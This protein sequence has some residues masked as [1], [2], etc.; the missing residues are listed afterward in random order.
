MKTEIVITSKGTSILSCQYEDDKLYEIW[1]EPA[2]PHIRLGD[3]YLGKVKN[4]VKNLN[5]AFVEIRPSVMGY[6]SLRDNKSHHFA[7]VKKNDRLCEGDEIL[8]QVDGENIKAKEWQLTGKI[9][10]Q[11]SSCV[12]FPG[13]SGVRVS[14]KIKDPVLRDHLKE[15]ALAEDLPGGVTI[16]TA[17]SS[18]DDRNIAIELRELAHEGENV[19]ASYKTRTCGS[20]L[21]A[22]ESI[23][24]QMIK[25]HICDPDCVI[26][27]DLPRVY[28]QVSSY[29]SSMRLDAG[30]PAPQVRLYEDENFS[31][32]NLKGIND[33]IEKACSRRVWL[34]SG[35]YLI[36]DNTEAMSV[37]DVN[38]WKNIRRAD[39]EKLFFETNMEAAC[40]VMR[41]IRLRNLSG[42]ILVDFINM[43]SEEHKSQLF[44]KARELAQAD[45]IQTSVIDLTAL[46]ILEIT[47]RRSRHSLQEML[48]AEGNKPKTVD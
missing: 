34:R 41:Q 33:Q 36:I 16:R 43:R 39:T 23:F 45:P 5:A 17:A 3:I 31:L 32:T 21:R 40:E 18:A 30:S 20:L 47:R 44:V 14:R 9:S 38:T 28:E 8:V 27:T 46:Q 48:G 2:G 29:I 4:I 13:G 35:G 37:I 6:Y 26:T 10:I 24:M 11:G 1:L 19:M 25:R 42:M 22:G 7:N 15:L 12:Y